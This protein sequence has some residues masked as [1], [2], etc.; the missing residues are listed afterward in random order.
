[1][2]ASPQGG[3]SGDALRLLEDARQRG[4]RYLS[5]LQTRAVAPTASAIDALRRLDTL[6][7]ARHA[8]LARPRSRWWSAARRTRA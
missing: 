7:A 3:W 8:V 2:S 5:D 6:A 4:A 1:V